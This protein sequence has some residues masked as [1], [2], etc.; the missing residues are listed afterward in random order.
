MVRYNVQTGHSVYLLEERGGRWYI[1]KIHPKP[2]SAEFAV[3]AFTTDSSALSDAKEN[4]RVALEK[5]GTYR[6]ADPLEKG[7]FI[8][9]T[10]G[11]TS[12]IRATKEVQLKLAA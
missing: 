2:E 11:C 8:L 4:L 12:Q 10:G 6:Y 3:V 5:A 9:H 7:A 1:Q